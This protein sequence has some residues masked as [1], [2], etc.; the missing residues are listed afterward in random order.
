MNVLHIDSS[1]LGAHSVSRGLTAA[2]VTELKHEQPG[3]NVTYR[4]V[5]ANPLPHWA[6]VADAADP[7]ATMGADVMDEFL[8]ADV[9]VIGAPMYNFGIPSALKAWIDRIAVAGKT[10]RYTAEGPEGLA[11]GKRVIVASSRG[12][13]Y[14]A[15]AAAAMDFQE[16]YLR[17]VLGFIGI[18]DVEFV[19]AEGVNVSADHKNEALQSAQAAIGGVIRKAA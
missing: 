8:A 9:V 3:L 5:A 10:F 14:S 11:K 18:T 1:A 15:G 7:A 19:R 2:I 6:P 16:S 12:G 17:A 13:F 4:D